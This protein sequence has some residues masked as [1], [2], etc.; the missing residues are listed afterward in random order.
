[1]NAIH[2][3]YGTQL[4]GEKIDATFQKLQNSALSKRT[5]KKH[6]NPI[7]CVHKECK[8]LKFHNILNLQNYLFMYQIQYS[9]KLIASFSA[10]HAKDKH[11]YNTRS[12]IT[13][14]CFLDIPL[15]KTNMYG[16]NT[17]WNNLKKLSDI[18]NSEISL[19]K[20]KKLS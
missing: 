8:I 11:N 14:H 18:S 16:K 12:G 6:H 19:S 15:T 9:P 13:S 2:L 1:M 10:L 3:Q 20:I 5:F 7:S 17:Y 4:W